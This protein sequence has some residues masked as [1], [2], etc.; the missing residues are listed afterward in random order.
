MQIYTMLKIYIKRYRLKICIY[1][2]I[3]IFLGFLSTIIPILTGNF[4]DTLISEND[5]FV[6]YKFCGAIIL[7]YS[8]KLILEYS[9]GLIYVKVQTKMGYEL[10][11]DVIFH[12]QK[13]PYSFMD[14]KDVAYMNQI[15][16]NDSNTLVIFAL[17]TIQD[18]VINII[19]LF[20]PLTYT[21]YINYK[22]TI[23]LLLLIII[24]IVAFGILKKDIY[25]YSFHLNEHKSLFFSKLQ[26]QLSNIKF[27]IINSI[28]KEM[29]SRLD[30]S[31]INLYESA[32]KYQK[33]NF[34]FSGLNEF[35]KIISQIVIYIFGGIQIIKGNFSI[36]ILTIFI[37]Y[38]NTMMSSVSYFYNF[39]KKYQEIRVSYNRL[40]KIIDGK[41]ESYGNVY[42]S[43][44]K[45]IRTKSLKVK[46]KNNTEIV[47]K[48]NFNFIR[49]NL[50]AI[51]GENG[52]G[53][54][55][56]INLILGMYK[57]ERIGK[58]LY[59]D[60]NIDNININYSRKKCFG[61]SEQ[62]TTL[63]HDTLRYNLLFT[64]EKDEQMDVKIQELSKMIHFDNYINT[65]DKKL[66]YIINENNNN[67]SGGEKQKISI[68]RVLL[69]NPDVMIFDEPN[70]FLDT[71][72]MTCL[73]E[74]LLSIK[75]NKII[76]IITHDM[77]L[78][79]ICDKIYE[80]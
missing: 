20:I 15:V 11:K 32:I 18:V 40:K 55:T 22:I 77:R 13:L 71:E 17:T 68:L 59:N 8:I 29:H 80:L 9:A 21:M 60:I 57:N 65:L 3:C 10:N 37:S 12:I 48:E 27:I 39:G 14:N 25:K 4:I 42:I 47:Y 46:Y 73:L 78:I 49:G 69:K 19:Y 64:N 45:E 26:E 62:D 58:I 63:L 72:S 33:I 44:I 50:Y 66:G 51:K 23:Y 67:L 35:I 41:E 34:L 6:V 52:R 75:Y 31:F 54:S 2:L 24:F 56:L 79:E 61:V 76:I 74:Y 1:I 36:G 70:S 43:E 30:L 38:F 28:E 7:I 16:N 53:K 5:I